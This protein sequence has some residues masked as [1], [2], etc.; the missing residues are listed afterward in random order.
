MTNEELYA[1]LKTE[2]DTDPL[3]RGYSG[4]TDEEIVTSLTGTVDRTVDK[5]TMTPEEIM[6]AFDDSEFEALT[7]GK[8]RKVQAV[9]T[10]GDNIPVGPGTVARQ[11]LVNATTGAFPNG[12]ATFTSLS[13]A[14]QETVNRSVEL[15]G[16]D[17]ILGDVQNARSLP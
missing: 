5:D 8:Y 17:V 1:A 2:L 7:E 4:M 6:A 16:R 10:L 11:W 15:F 3:A 14:V 12:T 13:S 9:L